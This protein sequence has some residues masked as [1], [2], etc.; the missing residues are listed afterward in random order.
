MYVFAKI[1]AKGYSVVG[2]SRLLMSP[3]TVVEEWEEISMTAN[4]CWMRYN[5]R[6]LREE[7]L[8]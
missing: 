6:V 3:M 4:L 7:N 1:H 8:T 2:V 5:R